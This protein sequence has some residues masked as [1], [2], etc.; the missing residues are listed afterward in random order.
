LEVMQNNDDDV[1]SMPQI[2]I[3]KNAPFHRMADDIEGFLFYEN[4]PKPLVY[5]D[6]RLFVYK[7]ATTVWH[8]HHTDETLMCQIVGNKKVA[9]LPPDEKTFEAVNE[10]FK[11]DKYL[12]SEE[13]IREYQN[14]IKDLDLSIVEVKQGDSLYIPPFWWHVV[15]PSS[16]DFGVTLAKCWRTPLHVMGDISFP[17]VR[18]MWQMALTK[19]NSLTFMVLYYGTLSVCAKYARRVFSRA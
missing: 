16:N 14:T 19:L 12:E 10:M 4:P 17:A 3:S 7:G 1:L 11:N 5:P 6:M 8:I 18:E 2:D 13:S 15:I 9:L